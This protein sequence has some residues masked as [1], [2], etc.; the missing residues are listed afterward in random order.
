MGNAMSDC[1]DRILPF[2][3]GS[4]DLVALGLQESTYS[5]RGASASSSTPQAAA[6]S[7]PGGEGKEGGGGEDSDCVLQLVAQVQEVLSDVF[8]MVRTETRGEARGDGCVC[9]CGCG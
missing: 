3:G 7:S 4:Y 5:L 9:G 8:Y 1:F 2:Q 6:A